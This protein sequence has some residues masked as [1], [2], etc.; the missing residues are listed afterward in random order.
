M[1]GRKTTPLAGPE[2]P[3]F[4]KETAK[5]GSLEV[6][7]VAEPTEANKV[8]EIMNS[9]DRSRMMRLLMHTFVEKVQAARHFIRVQNPS[10]VSNLSSPKRAGIA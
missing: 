8:T 9:R 7:V 3:D 10:Q 5:F 6:G 1:A 2:S 4:S